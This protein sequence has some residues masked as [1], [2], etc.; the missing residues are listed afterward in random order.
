MEETAMLLTSFFKAGELASTLALI[1]PPRHSTWAIFFPSWSFS[2][3]IITAIMWCRSL[4]VP[5]LELA[6]PAGV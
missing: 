5:R 6:I 4:A 3:S 1:L 2:G